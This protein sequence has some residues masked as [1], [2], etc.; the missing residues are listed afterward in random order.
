MP[1]LLLLGLSLSLSSCGVRGPVIELCSVDGVSMPE[2][3]G[4]AKRKDTYELSY[5]AMEGYICGSRVDIERFF[6]ACRDNESALVDFCQ[7]SDTPVLYC[8]GIRNDEPHFYEL[9]WAQANN[10]VCTS[11]SDFRRFIQWCSR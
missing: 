7:I 4:C 5:T 8:A 9:T 10:Y 11:P 3:A 1:C 6:Q 2:V